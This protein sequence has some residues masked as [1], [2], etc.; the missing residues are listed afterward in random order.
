MTAS[1]MLT[2]ATTKAECETKAYVC[3]EAGQFRRNPVKLLS[4]P[5]VS[6]K[7][8]SECQKCDGFMRQYYTWTPVCA[9]IQKYFYNF[10]SSMPRGFQGNGRRFLS[11]DEISRKAIFGVMRLM[12]CI[13]PD[14]G[15][16]AEADDTA[17][18]RLLGY[19]A[20]K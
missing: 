20:S 7:N 14:Y 4:P 8:E 16:E 13:I 19:Y 10:I 5:G 3:Q 6:L 15:T 17:T 12:K 9:F 11:K 1:V 18:L 2:K